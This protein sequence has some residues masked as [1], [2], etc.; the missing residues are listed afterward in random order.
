MV[1]NSYSLTYTLPIT[2]L[3]TTTIT[4]T[5]SQRKYASLGSNSEYTFNFAVAGGIG[6]VEGYIDLS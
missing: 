6:L 2:P 4:A 3:S 5:I 1:S